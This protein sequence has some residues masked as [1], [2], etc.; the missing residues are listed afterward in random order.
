MLLAAADRFQS[1]KRVEHEI[2][3]QL[4][5]LN[6]IG[7]DERKIGVQGHIEGHVLTRGIA[8]QEAEHLANDFAEIEM[9]FLDRR[10]FEQG[11]DSTNDIAGILSVLDDP[12]CC[13]H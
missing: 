7:E 6:P 12:F 4:L 1:L 2:Q 3:Y 13:L 9:R 8:V 11:P 5:K 10:P